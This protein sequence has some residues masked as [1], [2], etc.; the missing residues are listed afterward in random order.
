MISKGEGRR[1]EEGRKGNWEGRREKRDKK[2]KKH[3]E[4]R[5]ENEWQYIFKQ[6]PSAFIPSFITP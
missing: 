3:D 5:Q 1:R 2:K 6:S 4:T